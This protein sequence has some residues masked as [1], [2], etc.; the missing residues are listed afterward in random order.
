VRHVYIP[1]Q[2]RKPIQMSFIADELTLTREQEQQMAREEANLRESEEQVSLASKTVQVDTKKQVAGRV[3]EGDRLAETIRAETSRKIAAIGKETAAL[4]SEAEKVR[5]EA[6]NRGKQL[7]EEAKAD[8]FRLAV[9]AFG[10]PQAYNNW[11]FATGM[12][13]DVELQLL[14][15][16]PGTLWTDM[17][18]QS[19]DF[20]VRAT[21]PLENK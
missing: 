10:T 4:E 11:I 6:E 21:I 9:Q 18:R 17:N 14:Y 3:A 12:P 13:D 20:G 1:E 5:G 8:R 2:V 16:G 19:G 7:I 15:A